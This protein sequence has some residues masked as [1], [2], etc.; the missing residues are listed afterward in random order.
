MWQIEPS[1][2]ITIKWL[3]KLHLILKNTKTFVQ[4]LDQLGGV[5]E[6]KTIKKERERERER[7][8]GNKAMDRIKT[9]SSLSPTADKD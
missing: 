5:K 3:T 2:S 9:A 7:D 1:V 8:T 4:I 6:K